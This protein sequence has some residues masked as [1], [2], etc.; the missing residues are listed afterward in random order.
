[1]KKKSGHKNSRNVGER[2]LNSKTKEENERKTVKSRKK[3]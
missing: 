1:M 2:L 3:N